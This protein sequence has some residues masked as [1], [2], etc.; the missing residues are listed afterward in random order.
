VDTS[1]DIHRIHPGMH[2]LQP[3][4]MYPVYKTEVLP[5][6]EYIFVTLVCFTTNGSKQVAPEVKIN[7]ENISLKQNGKAISIKVE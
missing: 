2:L 1:Y 4:A 3:Q 7:G 5:K 6:G